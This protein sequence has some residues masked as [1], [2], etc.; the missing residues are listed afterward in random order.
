MKKTISIFFVTL[1]SVFIFSSCETE[2]QE[3][4]L[5]NALGIKLA[6]SNATKETVALFYN[7]Q[8][9]SQTK[10]LF[11]HHHTTA[12][13]VKWR[14]DENRSDVKDVTGVYPALYGWDI[15]DIIKKG[16]L[17]SPDLC[18][19][20][21][22]EAYDRGG[23]N[24][25]AWHYD[26]PVTNE[27]F[28]DTT[29]A[30]KHILP[31]GSHHNEFLKSL[32][33]IADFAQNIKGKNG[34]LIPIIFRPWHEF[35]GSWFWWGKRFCTAEEFKELF[36]FTVTYLRDVKNVH[37]FLYAFSPDRMIYSEEDYLDR[38]P[39]DE[40][41]DILGMDDYWDFNPRGEGLEAISNKL[42]LISTLAA[43]RNKIAAFT[44]T[45]S[46]SIPD[47]LWWTTRLLKTMKADTDSIN[48]AYVMVWR[49]DNP[50][51]HYAP[52]QGHNSVEDFINFKNDSLIIFEDEIP[53]LYKLPAK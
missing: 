39:G 25:F 14:Y 7:L 17:V 24:T 29:V 9:A 20:L 50:K 1:I 15:A 18:V 11:G 16:G 3:T 6:D 10:T 43:N 12:Y 32:D 26:N 4:N 19:K 35:D 37:N 8:K 2:K 34:E 13:G 36:R 31:E 38:Y 49:N 40:Y 5:Q 45:G 51:H 23:V 42:K 52:Y 44:E 27:N 48:L 22:T 46:E 30:V 28:Y 41:V 53:S 47:S 33:I 21:L